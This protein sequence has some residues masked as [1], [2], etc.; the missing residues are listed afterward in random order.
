MTELDVTA[1]ELAKLCTPDEIRIYQH[2]LEAMAGHL[3]QMPPGATLQ[4]CAAE[5]LLAAAAIARVRRAGSE[6]H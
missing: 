1:Q 5:L 3:T 4:G 2:V 6:L